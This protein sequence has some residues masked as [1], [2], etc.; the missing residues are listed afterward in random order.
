MFRAKD[1][2]PEITAKVIR[3]EGEGAEGDAFFSEEEGKTG[4]DVIENAH[5]ENKSDEESKL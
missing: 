1:I 3:F 2:H 5:E 4:T